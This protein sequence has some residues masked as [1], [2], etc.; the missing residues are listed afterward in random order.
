MKEISLLK[1]A[2]FL[3]KLD[4]ENI[5]VHYIKIIVLDKNENPLRAIEGRV[6]TGSININ[7]NSA[8][9][10]AGSLTFL[11]EETENDLTDIDNL[12]SMNKK[13]RILI[14]VENHI[15]TNYD[16]IIWFPLGIF[17][18][19]NPSLT[20]STTGVKINIQFN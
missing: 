9:R 14:G 19:S 5:K 11:A 12:L 17:I 15:D 4:I 10:R 1:D 20:H 2:P 18:I 7:G 6:S 16:D 3:R 13:I 8:V